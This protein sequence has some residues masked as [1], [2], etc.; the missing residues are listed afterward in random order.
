MDGGFFILSVRL[1]ISH[2]RLTYLLHDLVSR[3]CKILINAHFDAIKQC[4][5]LNAGLL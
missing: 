2:E 4:S 1:T 5:R 3:T